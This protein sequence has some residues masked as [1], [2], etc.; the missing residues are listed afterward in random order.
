[1][2]RVGPCARKGAELA[3]RRAARRH[4]HG[5]TS[6]RLAR[7]ARASASARPRARR[8]VDQHAREEQ[9]HPVE[10]TR[11]VGPSVRAPPPERSRPVRALTLPVVRQDEPVKSRSNAGRLNPT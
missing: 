1:V 4:R 9:V 2:G 10:D 6:S 11:S 3:E 7:R 8:C 5:E